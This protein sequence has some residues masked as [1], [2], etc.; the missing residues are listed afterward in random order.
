MY[1]GCDVD[2]AK[3]D[4]TPLISDI[5]VR[6]YNIAINR[7]DWDIFFFCFHPQVVKKSPT[8]YEIKKYS[9]VLAISFVE[10]TKTGGVKC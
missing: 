2:W 1:S 4:S 5:D 7:D 8:S 9:T 6:N 3:E 10:K